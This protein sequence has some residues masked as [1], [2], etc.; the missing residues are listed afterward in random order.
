MSR[1]TQ[2]AIRPSPAAAP[3]RARRAPRSRPGH[4]CQRRIVN[5]RTRPPMTSATLT[6]VALCRRHAHDVADGDDAHQ[7]AVVGHRHRAQVVGQQ[8]AARS[9]RRRDAWRRGGAVVLHDVGARDTR[10]R[11]VSNTNCWTLSDAALYR[12]QAIAAS[13]M[14]LIDVAVE[15]QTAGRRRTCPRRRPCPRWPPIRSPCA[16][17]RWC[18]TGWRAA[19]ARR[20]AGTR[21]PG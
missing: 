3:G 15:E 17:C 14:P 2:P 8:V 18:P 5:S 10:R 20:R 19:R 11:R 16:H 1:P 6:R 21:A 12:N 9:A 4:A 13:Q 7:P